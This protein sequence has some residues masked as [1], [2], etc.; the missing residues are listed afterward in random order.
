MRRAL[1]IIVFFMTFCSSQAQTGSGMLIKTSPFSLLPSMVTNHGFLVFG[2]EKKIKNRI[3]FSQDLGYLIYYGE[4]SDI[5]DIRVK[6]VSG[7]TLRSE[8]RRY[9]GDNESDYTG[10]YLGFHFMFNYSRATRTQTVVDYP[11]AA[12]HHDYYVKRNVSAVHVTAGHQV[13]MN[14][15]FTFDISSGLGIRRISSYSENKMERS[16]IEFEIPYN[17]P[18]DEGT[19][20]FPSVITNVK[21]GYRI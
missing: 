3:S 5:W 17:K 1:T 12:Y 10:F 19:R 9:F 7:F 4:R 14:S 18:Y 6:D 8:I 20:F 21:F 11:R 16:I 2:I 13:H 15:R